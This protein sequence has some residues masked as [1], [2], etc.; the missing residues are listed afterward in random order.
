MRAASVSAC[1]AALARRSA[2]SMLPLA[3]QATTTTFMPAM[4]ALA[5]LVP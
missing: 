1:A 3:S 2:T 4:T 5:G